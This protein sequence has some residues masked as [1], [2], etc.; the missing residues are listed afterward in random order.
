MGDF[1]NLMG[2]GFRLFNSLLSSDTAHP[3]PDDERT[4][5]CIGQHVVNDVG[6]IFL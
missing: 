6:Q 5:R 2:R 3:T 1:V 4:V